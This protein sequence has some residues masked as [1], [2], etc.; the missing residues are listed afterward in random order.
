MRR[1][2]GYRRTFVVGRREARYPDA[3]REALEQLVEHDRDD[4]RGCEEW[5]SISGRKDDNAKV[6]G[7]ALNS[8]PRDI[9]S[10]KPMTSE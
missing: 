7:D 3:E 8:G 9:D 4:D 6:E 1:T 10:V 5:R 2:A